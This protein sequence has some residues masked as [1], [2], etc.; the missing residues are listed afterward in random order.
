MTEKGVALDGWAKFACPPRTAVLFSALR[1]RLDSLLAD[2]VARP[3]AD[4]GAASEELVA[5]LKALL[6][7]EAAA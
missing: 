4:I 5:A 3:A 6:A 7:S 2:K 1:R